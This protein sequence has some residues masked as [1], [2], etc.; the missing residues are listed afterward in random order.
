MRRIPLWLWFCATVLPMVWLVLNSVRSSREIF[1]EPFG[2][3]SGV[4]VANYVG[5]WTVAHFGDYFVNSLVV[6]VVSVLFTVLLGAMAAYGLARFVFPGSQAVLFFFLGGMMVPLQLAVVPLFFEMGAL[7]LLN[8]RLGLML[9][10]VASGLPFAIFIL[11]GFFRSLPNELYESAQL[12]GC[13]PW[14]AFWSIMLP[15][16]QP[17]LITV[18]VFTFLG[19]WNE[20]FLAFMLLS[21]RGSEAVR[22][23]PLGLA[24]LTIVSQYRTDYGM[25]FAG[26]VLVMLPTLLVY[27]V[28]QR[29]VTKGVTMGALK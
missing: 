10:Y 12:D 16:A 25:L 14:R 29:Y 17:G 21:G 7:G 15:L 13:S 24:N 19:T 1:L 9:V 8:S 18:A 11:V 26:L 6:T 4:H 2:L 23:L 22:T 20:Y 27:A 5:A 3:P 28:L